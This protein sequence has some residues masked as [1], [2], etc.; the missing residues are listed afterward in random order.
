MLNFL[1]GLTSFRALDGTR[2]YILL[3]LGS[4]ADIF[5]FLFIFIYITIAF[6]IVNSTTIDSKNDTIFQI[7]WAKPYDMAHG[8]F[9]HEQDIGLEYIGF[10]FAS[11]F[12]IIVM[13]NLL[14]SILGDSYDKFQLESNKLDYK[15]RIGA[16][17]ECEVLLFWRARTEEAHHFAVCDFPTG[18]GKIGEDD[19]TGK[20][21]AIQNTM[22]AIEKKITN[23]LTSL[24]SNILK[25]LKSMK[26]S[27]KK[28]KSG[29]SEWA[30]KIISKLENLDPKNNSISPLKKQ[31]N[32]EKKIESNEINENK[33][34]NDE[35]SENKSENNES[36]EKKSVS[37]ESSGKKSENDDSSEQDDE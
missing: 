7:I 18:K 34:E 13:L 20:V 5:S 11:L 37:N 17:Y 21:F 19:W 14:I 16:V 30:K 23:S 31:N 29:E 33:S 28:E 9:D 32:S 36:S 10:F 2:F 1:R 4:V 12:I 22:T 27:A 25:E 6:G 24:E 15:E 35:R 26:E 8:T 3:I